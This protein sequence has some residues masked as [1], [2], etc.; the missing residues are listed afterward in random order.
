MKRLIAVILVLALVMGIAACGGKKDDAP[1]TTTKGTETTTKAPDKQ[2]DKGDDK[3]ED[4]TL[5]FQQWFADECPAGLFQEIC[6]G[7][8][9]Q[10]GVKIELYN[11][12]NSE[13]K[14]KLLTGAANGTIA[15]IVG[16][17][18][19]WVCDLVEGG[20]L[21][22]LD[23][24][25]ASENID[26]SVFSD[27]WVY[28]GSTYAMPM[29]TFCY[30]LAVNLDILA[31]AG[32]D[33]DSIKTRTDFLNACKAITDKGYLAYGWNAT[34][35]NPAGLDHY[36]LNSFWTSGG[37][38]RGDDGLFY[39]TDN[40]QFKDTAI[41]WK[42]LVDNGYIAPGYLTAIEADITAKFGSGDLAFCNPSISMLS[43]W[44]TDSPNLNYTVIPMP[45]ADDY[46]G[47]H[48]IDYACWGIG[49][50]EN[51]AHKAEAMQFINYMFSAEANAKLAQ[52]KGC[53]PGSTVSNPDYSAQSEKFQKAFEIWKSGIPR[54]EWN[55]AIEA[56]T[57][58]TGILENI[59]L[60]V[61]GDI[62]LDT[63]VA[64]CQKVCDDVYK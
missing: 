10:T 12:P 43:I 13:T 48:Y 1:E 49:I 54:A 29:V 7:F 18:G 20:A 55:A 60:Y 9:A 32:V 16:T 58:R 37:K 30:P 40:Q 44:D 39:L 17:D 3:Q 5:T 51:C 57:L 53:F 59:L 56:S 50:S 27:M 62:D 42:E 45:A 64:N 2:D 47:T 11:D 35:S 28:K 63:M 36:F 34:T 23:D 22:P 46:T 25:F 52:G 24:L 21:T 4:I 6:D 33:P 19:K 15:D 26:T 61:T 8:T 14:T 38:L 31:D 41:F